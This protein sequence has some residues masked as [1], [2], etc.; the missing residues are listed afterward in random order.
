MHIRREL[1][2]SKVLPFPFF[3]TLDLLIFNVFQVNEFEVE[4]ADNSSTPSNE[5]GISGNNAANRIYFGE[6]ISTFFCCVKCILH[7][8]ASINHSA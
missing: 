6:S 3:S 5:E 7:L 1:H 2:S 8:V 4:M